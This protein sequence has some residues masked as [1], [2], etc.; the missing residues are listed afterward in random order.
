MPVIEGGGDL[1]VL[2]VAVGVMCCMQQR[3]RNGQAAPRAA[4]QFNPTY[5]F[6]APSTSSG[7]VASFEE[8]AR[9]GHADVYPGPQPATGH[10]NLGTSFADAERDVWS[11]A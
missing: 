11:T 1:A 4:A 8:S 10:V 2:A 6:G 7:T 5:D 3:Q 9:A